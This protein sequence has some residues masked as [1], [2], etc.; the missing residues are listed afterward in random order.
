VQGLALSIS[1]SILD[2][3]TGCLHHKG[4]QLNK[5]GEH[6]TTAVLPRL[7]QQLQDPHCAVACK[8]GLLTCGAVCD[9]LAVRA[10][11]RWHARLSS[12][13]AGEGPQLQSTSAGSHTQSSADETSRR[14]F[15]S[16]P[17]NVISAAMQ[18]N[19]S[20]VL[21]LLLSFVAGVGC[22]VWGRRRAAVARRKQACKELG[23][24]V[25]SSTSG[26]SGSEAFANRWEN[27]PRT[28][29]ARRGMV[30]NNPPPTYTI[31]ALHPPPLGATDY[32]PE[33]EDA[34]GRESN[35]MP[36]RAGYV[37]HR[38][39]EFDSRVPFYRICTEINATDSVANTGDGDVVPEG[40]VR[41]YT[42]ELQNK[43][44]I[45]GTE[46]A[47]VSEKNSFSRIPIA[48]EKDVELAGMDSGTI[49]E[50]DVERPGIFNG[51]T[52]QKDVELPGI[53]NGTTSQKDVESTGIVNG[54]KADL[55]AHCAKVLFRKKNNSSDV[56]E[57]CEE[58]F[59]VVESMLPAAG[60]AGGLDYPTALDMAVLNMVTSY[61]LMGVAQHGDPLSQ[62][63]K[64]KA[65][66]HRTAA[67]R[68]AQGPDPGGSP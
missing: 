29:F 63:P 16:I 56:M 60:F 58:S 35:P 49:S 24:A 8:A 32:E 1:M 39:A 12:A 13:S 10:W 55:L 50:K 2:P 5:P 40:F 28:P 22:I 11:L 57:E 41:A 43:A 25:P 42:Q 54:T 52:L 66:A 61:E 9:V 46:V 23:A 7:L 67:A 45:V 18:R 36:G 17:T 19:H 6:P 33:E 47:D 48:S 44:A 38:T 34:V 27:L 14:A 15:Q 51:A 20:T 64:I 26:A 62:Y 4:V 65:L 37:A 30:T 31:T 53:V 59:R 3:I 68:A 21:A